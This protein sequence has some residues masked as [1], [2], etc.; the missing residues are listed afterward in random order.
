VL[1]LPEVQER[2]TGVGVELIGNSPE[3]FAQF[4]KTEIARWSRVV[5]FSGAQ[6]D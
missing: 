5:K 2:L 4:I 6:I 1:A 3:E